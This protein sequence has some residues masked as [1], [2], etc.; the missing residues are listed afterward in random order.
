MNATAPLELDDE[1]PHEPP[2][3]RLAHQPLPE[4][5]VVLVDE[6]EVDVA[7]LP[8]CPVELVAAGL[9]PAPPTPPAGV[10]PLPPHAATAHARPTAVDWIPKRA[11]CVRMR[12]LPDAPGAPPR[13]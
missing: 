9:A 1:P 5:E 2:L 12:A 6:P 11:F 4:D 3:P 8:P 7:E 13:R 10:P